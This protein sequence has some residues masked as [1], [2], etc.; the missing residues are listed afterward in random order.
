M[1][2][3]PGVLRCREG[4][5][6]EDINRIIF[7]VKGLVHPSDKIVAFPRFVPDP[8]G[9]RV[10][11][12]VT[13]RKIYA[14]S[15][16]LAFLQTH[17]PQYLTFDEAFGEN[18]CEIPKEEIVRLHEPTNRLTELRTTSRLDRLEADALYLLKT[19]H[20]RANVPWA[21]LGISGSLLV[22]LHS[23]ESDIDPIVYGA[24]EGAR[25]YETLRALIGERE[26][27]VKAYSLDDLKQLY[28]FRSQD[29]LVE[30]D[31]FVKTER[32]K[33]L[34]GRFLGHDYF[35]RCIRD[36]QEQEE[37]YGETVY[38]RTGY[39]RIK[40]EVTDDS[41]AIFT[42]CRYLVKNVHLLE[43][44]G[45]DDIVEVTSFRGRFC[46]QARIGEIIVAQGKVEKVQTKNGT[47]HSRVLLGGQPSDFMVLET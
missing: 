4:D 35:V 34:Q 30:F 43:G 11:V 12:G 23:T 42:P 29:T 16:R 26:S 36:W 27:A 22:M 38:Q 9:T 14:L 41:E 21:A 19:L 32:R 13:Y 8:Q 45:A 10:R 39:A 18:L 5:Y 6:V 17:F 15:E 44:K 37:H 2:E 3:I 33:V 20:K 40:S 25:T 24:A 1:Q 28:E 31:D 7:D 46:E 47:T